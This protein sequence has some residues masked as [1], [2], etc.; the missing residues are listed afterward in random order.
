[1]EGFAGSASLLLERYETSW[2]T[3]RTRNAE[4]CTSAQEV[5]T[6][7]RQAGERCT[8]AE[9]SWHQ[10]QSE[11]KKLPAT[12]QLVRDMTERTA[13]AVIQLEAL[14]DQLTKLTMACVQRQEERWRRRR[15]L[16][17]VEHETTRRREVEQ[18]RVRVT[19]ETAR[20]QQ[21]IQQERQHIFD[22]QFEEQRQYVLQHGEHGLR[23]MEQS[24]PQPAGNCDTPSSL[25]QVQP[26]VAA[27][28]DELDAFYDD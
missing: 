9:L 18:V 12:V 8:D 7:S 10:L 17:V 24:M 16:E 4:I 2:D 15:L 3:L 11:V 25:A 21:Q 26:G 27:A 14:E 5:R 19:D 1:M 23:K 20:Q 22:H 13:A 6:A 28:A